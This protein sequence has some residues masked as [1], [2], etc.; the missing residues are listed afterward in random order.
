MR[1]SIA[2]SSVFYGALVMALM[3]P[4]LVT[5]RLAPRGAP[6]PRVTCGTVDT[7]HEQFLEWVVGHWW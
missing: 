7:E 1:N 5:L 3:M 4:L 2:N 6:S